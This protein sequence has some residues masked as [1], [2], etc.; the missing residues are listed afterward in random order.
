MSLPWKRE[1]KAETDSE[2]SLSDTSVFFTPQEKVSEDEAASDFRE[3]MR[4]DL[5][6]DP[7]PWILNV[8]CSDRFL[9]FHNVFQFPDS[10]GF[11]KI[12]LSSPVFIQWFV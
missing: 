12:F 3:S 7:L 4:I 1:G 9:L 8:S 10:F 5:S 11:L 6:F 2:K